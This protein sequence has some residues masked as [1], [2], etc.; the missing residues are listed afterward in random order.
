MSEATGTAFDL[1]HIDTG[2]EVTEREQQF[3]SEFRLHRRRRRA[4]IA[5]VTILLYLIKS[6]LLPGDPFP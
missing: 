2:E 1:E 6:G 5:T 3:L 4:V